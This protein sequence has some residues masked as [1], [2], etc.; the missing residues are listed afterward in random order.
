MGL[1][2]DQARE[3]AVR[4][5]RDH[6]RYLNRRYGT[7]QGGG[8]YCTPLTRT[9]EVLSEVRNARTSRSD[10]PRGTA[11]ETA[12]FLVSMEEQTQHGQYFDSYAATTNFDKLLHLLRLLN[13]D[14]SDQRP[15]HILRTIRDDYEER[16]QAERHFAERRRA[17]NEK[18]KNKTSRRPSDATPPMETP[19]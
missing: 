15:E 18:R 7:P 10:V 4:A 3:R 6:L 9:A 5:A 17:R 1:D 2:H 13:D 12:R 8:E 11:E 19:P 16:R 14:H